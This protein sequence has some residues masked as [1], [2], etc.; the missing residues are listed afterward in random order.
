MHSG[1]RSLGLKRG[2]LP[3]T[4][5][6]GGGEDELAEADEAAGANADGPAA[7]ADDAKLA[8]DAAAADEEEAPAS[9]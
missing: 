1:V 8:D 7:A 4:R 3:V 2:F 9:A 5:S 6:G